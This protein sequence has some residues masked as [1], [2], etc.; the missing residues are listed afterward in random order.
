MAEDKGAGYSTQ[1]WQSRIVGYGRAAPADLLANPYNFRRHPAEQRAALEGILDRV[2]WVQPVIVNRTTG[3]ILDGHLRVTLA[4]RHSD[5][6]IDVAYVEMSED[7]E[8]LTL[9]LLDK[10]AG[11]AAV[12]GYKLDALLKQI[13]EQAAPVQIV[14]ENMAAD[15]ILILLI[16][17]FRRK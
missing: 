8:R 1:A 7:E 9:A 16:N 13:E 5:L 3:H 12:D 2:G 6:E 10:L 15:K 14:L 11:M 17:D 4:M